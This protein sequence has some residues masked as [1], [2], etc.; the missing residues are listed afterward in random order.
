LLTAVYLSKNRGT[1]SAQEAHGLD[2]DSFFLRFQLMQGGRWRQGLPAQ[3]GLVLLEDA[4]LPT[5]DASQGSAE[6]R[7]DNEDT[8]FVCI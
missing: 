3:G 6:T 1:V 5:A 8:F 7:Y 2:Q 4:E